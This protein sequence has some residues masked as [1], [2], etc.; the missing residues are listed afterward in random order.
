MDFRTL[1]RKELQALCKRNKIPANITN[2]AMADALA[3]LSSVE[4]I[5]E[6]FNGERSG[7]P[8]S[9]MK[10]E[11]IS[12]E[13]P[14]TALRTSTR[15]KAVKD[16]AITTRT[17]RAAA[18]RDTEES[19]NRDLNV[20]LTTPSLP[21]SRRRTAAA[22]SACKKVD[23]QMTVDDQKEDN[24]LDKKKKA[25][26]KTPAVP[27]SLRV[28]G[29]STRKRT[30]TRNNGAAEQRVYSTRRSVRFLEK[31]MESLS[32]GEDREMESITVHMSFDD[33]PNSSGPVKEDTELETESKK[34]DESE[35]KLDKDTGVEIDDQEKNE[36]ESEVE[37]SEEEQEMVLDDPLKSSEEK[38][39]TANNGDDTGT[40]APHA[41]SDVKCFSEDEEANEASKDDVSV[42]ISAEEINDSDKLSQPTEDGDLTEV[43]DNSIIVEESGM[44]VES[45]QNESTCELKH[46]IE[47]VINE[48]VKL[49]NDTAEKLSLP[50]ENV[51]EEAQVDDDV[52][53]S[54]EESVMEVK[55]DQTQVEAENESTYE[56]EHIIEKVNEEEVK[57]MKD[58][59]EE[60]SLPH[61]SVEEKTQV[62]DGV[63]SSDE[64]SVIEVK[65]DQDEYDYESDPTIE[66]EAS[67]ADIEVD[68]K[69]T[70]ME[71]V[72]VQA[73]EDDTTINTSME[74][75]P[76]NVSEDL[77]DVKIQWQMEEEAPSKDIDVDAIDSQPK[78]PNDNVQ[79]EE[80]LVEIIPTS[81]NN[82]GVQSLPSFGADQLALATQF[83]RPTVGTKSP[84]REQTIR[85]LMDNSDAEEEED[86][87][88]QEKANCI[89][90]QIVETNDMS[91]RQL[92]KM[93]KEKLQLSKQKMDNNSINSKVVGGGGKV[94]TALQPVPENIMTI[95]E[96]ERRF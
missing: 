40:E 88:E 86:G 36:M 8:E 21:G 63:L 75:F 82:N 69:E 33:M 13:I 41:N 49:M 54:D 74:E 1:S 70:E 45:K 2:V 20:A 93:F 87:K 42:E 9:P 83:P 61:E 79:C 24:D 77:V 4:G 28:A 32:L 58:T 47:E 26:E 48:E 80:A 73:E 22:S 52:L 53:S 66:E 37:L 96:L 14:R 17:R 46:I 16:E 19:E 71:K 59:A 43:V 81:S 7:V 29:A 23:F 68:K 91:L 15:R 31:N 55:D 12:S 18:A 92:K 57:L 65:D 94:R 78:I 25:I 30:E 35:S 51:E 50:H 6:F 34:S 39:A 44:E 38:P 76:E 3:A 62:D 95:N 27:K 84:V 5:E 11:V 56:L 90:K 64:E 85:L 89:E 10:P 60:L 67:D 72:S